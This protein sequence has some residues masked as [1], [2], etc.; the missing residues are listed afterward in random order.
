[1]EFSVQLAGQSF[2]KLGQLGDEN[3]NRTR[4]RETINVIKQFVRRSLEK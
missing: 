4:Q 1:M 2:E 3:G